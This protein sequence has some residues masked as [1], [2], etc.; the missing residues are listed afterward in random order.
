M[1]RAKAMQSVEELMKNNF[2]YLCNRG[3][4]NI[5][6]IHLTFQMDCNSHNLQM[7][8]QFEENWCDVLCFISPTVIEIGTESHLQALQIVNYINWNVK[9]WGR[10]YID[11]FG[12]IAYSLRLHYN[13]LEKMPQ[14]CAKEIES[15]V[16]YYVDLFVPILNLC[17]DAVSFADTKRK[18]DETWGE[19][20]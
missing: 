5:N 11:E 7:T 17:K 3:N 13:V 2:K 12:D 4:Y 1:N 6:T 20:Q 15:A 19:I 8:L 9:A 16:D 10:Y 18:I 14:E